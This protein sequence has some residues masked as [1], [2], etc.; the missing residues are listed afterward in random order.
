MTQLESPIEPRSDAQ[1]SKG[2]K[3]VFVTYALLCIV[4][5]ISAWHLVEVFRQT[6]TAPEAHESFCNISEGM[7]CDKV[8]LHDE[9]SVFLGTPVAVWAVAGYLFVALLALTALFRARSGFAQGFLFLLGILFVVVSLWLIYAM[10]FEIGSWCIVCLSIDV[11]NLSLFGLSIAALRISKQRINASIFS[12]FRSLIEKPLQT[13][14]LAVVG[15]GLLFCA[16]RYG[17]NLQAQ[18]E[19]E[20]AALGPKDT[21]TEETQSPRMLYASRKDERLEEKSWSKKTADT[22]SDKACLV[23]KEGKESTASGVV[24]VGI[25]KAGHNWKGAENPKLEIFEFTD[26]ECPYCRNAHMMVNKLLARYAGQLRVVHRHLPL[27][28]ACNGSVQRPFHQRACELS[29]I[30]VCAGK[31]GRFFEMTDYLFHNAKTIRAENLSAEAIAKALELD[32]GKFNCCMEDPESMAPI[33]SDLKEAASLNLRGTPAF[34]INGQVYY[35]KIP[36]EALKPLETPA[37]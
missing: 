22:P 4:G 12:D 29:R 17:E 30:A 6:H 20:R 15:I 36:D 1:P 11:I 27:D 13:V 37:P 9:F 16:W 32:L 8:A 26:F 31:Q 18:I 19:K 34:V 25:D 24:Q 33:A 28:N 7:N 35:G 10:H 2:L 14:V 21:A 5:I 3:V 23:K